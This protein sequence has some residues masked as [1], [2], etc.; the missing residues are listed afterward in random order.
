MHGLCSGSSWSWEG[1]SGDRLHAEL[2]HRDLLSEMLIWGLTNIEVGAC[3]GFGFSC[4][5][6][7][8]DFQNNQI[9]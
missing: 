9:R 2:T 3:P 5:L 7:G 6:L 4:T 8:F 1:W